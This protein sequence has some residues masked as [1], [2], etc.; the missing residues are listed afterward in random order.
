MCTYHNTWQNVGPS[1]HCWKLTASLVLWLTVAFVFIAGNA[2]D[3]SRILE[4]PILW[5][6][7]QWYNEGL[8]L[9]DCQ[10][11]CIGALHVHKNSGKYIFP[12]HLVVEGTG[13]APCTWSLPL[14]LL[15]AWSETPWHK[16]FPWTGDQLLRGL[17]F[18]AMFFVQQ[19]QSGR[20]DSLVPCNLGS[21]H[22]GIIRMFKCFNRKIFLPT[23]SSKSQNCTI[24]YLLII[25]S[26]KCLQS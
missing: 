23:K 1:L 12:S 2:E 21:I 19:L 25:V 10:F 9:F 13:D 3:I 18:M 22:S 11:V 17:R 4:F 16:K 14:P 7:V 8:I 20:T 24:Y 5:L 6:L 26:L 15:L